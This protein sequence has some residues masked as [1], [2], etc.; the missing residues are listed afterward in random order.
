MTSG[1]AFDLGFNSSRHGVHHSGDITHGPV[2]GAT[3]YIKMY[4]A[5]TEASEAN[6]AALLAGLPGKLDKEAYTS[7]LATAGGEFAPI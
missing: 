5:V 6:M 2:I 4:G 1:T 3:P 7:A